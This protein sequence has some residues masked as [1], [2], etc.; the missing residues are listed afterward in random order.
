M[1]QFPKRENL[2]G[3]LSFWKIF[4]LVLMLGGIVL[5]APSAEA[6]TKGV[7]LSRYGLVD[8]SWT[9]NIV[10][11]VFTNYEE[12]VNPIKLGDRQFEGLSVTS[13]DLA[14]SQDCFI[15]YAN[16]P[17]KWALFT[18]F[19]QEGAAI[20]EAFILFHKL[21]F[22]LQAKTGIFRVNFMK[23]NQYHDHEWAFADPPLISTFFFGVD[24]VHNVGLE[25]NWQPPTPIF[26]ELSASLM[27]GPVGNFDRTF[28]GEWD[29]VAG[30][31]S[32]NEFVFFSRATTFFDLTLH[33]N[34]EFGASF[35][36]GK[37]K[38]NTMDFTDPGFNPLGIDAGL[39][40]RTILYGVDFTYQWKPAPYSPY[41]RWT[42]EYLAGKREN[43]VVLE[44]NRSVR[45]PGVDLESQVVRTIMDDDTIGGMYTE[46]AY[47]FSYYWEVDG[48]FDYVGI[49][50]GHEDR[51][52]RYTASLRYYINPV[53]RI[54][55]QYN[56]TDQ[57]GADE[58]YDVFYVQFNI[59]GGT[60]T[61]GLGK[62]Y[63][64][65]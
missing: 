41:V 34:L 47:R 64:L 46:L 52:A 59:G 54:S 38:S 48:R 2:S 3:H 20:E 1:S 22:Y 13:F 62:F 35:A 50:R 37:N 40:D 8:V 53:S 42:T 16:F 49:P 4:L 29:E 51:Q 55:F 28:P 23:L 18:A 27:R 5:R 36:T 25:F 65:F 17:C 44:L 56:Y 33:S 26:L 12:G 61:P 6:H 21:P 7:S 30:D 39:D 9:A 10:Y 32:A 58:D 14:F 45:A 19:E 15:L 31:L 11:G 60:V 63:N 57:S 24:G 43:P